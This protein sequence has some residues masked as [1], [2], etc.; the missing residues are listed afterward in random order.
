M[1]DSYRIVVRA[2]YRHASA[3]VGGRWFNK[4]TP[5]ILQATDVTP[6]ILK[7]PLLDVQPNT[8]PEMLASDAPANEPPAPPADVPGAKTTAKERKPRKPK[9][10][11]VPKPPSAGG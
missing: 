4:K 5:A 11:K 3:Q 7:S 2:D 1:V 9:A 8:P 6:E 10:P